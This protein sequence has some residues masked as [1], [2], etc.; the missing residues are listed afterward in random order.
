MRLLIGNLSSSTT[1]ETLR[2]AFSA[3]GEVVE[4]EI[5]LYIGDEYHSWRDSRS[6]GFAFVEMATREECERALEGLNGTT[7]DGRVLFVEKARP[8]VRRPAGAAWR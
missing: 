4:A 7:L 6:R 3:F 5:V 1:Q 2:Q 8:Y